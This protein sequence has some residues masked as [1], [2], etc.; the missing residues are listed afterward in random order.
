MKEKSLFI[1][2]SY[3]LLDFFRITVTT[4]RLSGDLSMIIYQ[5]VDD[6]DFV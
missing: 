2:F 1:I 5:R 6:S 3:C 4:H